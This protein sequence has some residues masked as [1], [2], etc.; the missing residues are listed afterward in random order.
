MSNAE[1]RHEIYAT[2][3][4]ETEML[5]FRYSEETIV[6]VSSVFVEHT[7]IVLLLHEFTEHEL[8]FFSIVV[9]HG[10]LREPLIIVAHD[11]QSFQFEQFLSLRRAV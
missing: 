2:L 7:N 3:T 1:T 10:E 4:L 8:V 6:V 11:A 9:G 5:H